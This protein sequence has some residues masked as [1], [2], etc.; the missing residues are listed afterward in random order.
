[1]NALLMMADQWEPKEIELIECE[2][3]PIAK[4]FIYDVI[5]FSR[6]P[7]GSRFYAW[8]RKK[9]RS[10]T[11]WADTLEGLMEVVK[12]RLNDNLL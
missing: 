5:I 12:R 8:T 11:L 10:W 2:V 4:T 7:G 3:G 9:T 1:M 6:T